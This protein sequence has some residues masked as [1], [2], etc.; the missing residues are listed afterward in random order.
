LSASRE[1]ARHLP[2]SFPAPS[3]AFRS[4]FFPSAL[5]Y[6]IMCAPVFDLTYIKTRKKREKK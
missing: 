6:I 5:Y 4:A 1:A 3:A 2:P